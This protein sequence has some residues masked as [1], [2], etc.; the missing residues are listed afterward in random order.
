MLKWILCVSEGTYDDFYL[1][2]VMW[3]NKC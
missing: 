1:F 2:E 3:L